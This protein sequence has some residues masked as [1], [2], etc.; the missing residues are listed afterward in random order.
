MG[1]SKKSKKNLKL[2]LKNPSSTPSQGRDQGDNQEEKTQVESEEK[3]SW[4]SVI[5]SSLETTGKKPEK[6][7]RQPEQIVPFKKQSEK[8]TNSVKEKKEKEIRD[9]IIA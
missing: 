1:K 3:K 7:I 9:K 6:I 8:H 2:V 4:S 5:K